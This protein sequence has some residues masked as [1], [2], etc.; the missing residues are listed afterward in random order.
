MTRFFLTC[1]R[2]VLH[3]GGGWRRLAGL[4]V[5]ALV[6]ML[7][8]AALP[9]QAT[10][11][12]GGELDLQYLRGE[13]YQLR[14]TL[15]FDMKGDLGAFDN[16]LTASLFE[17]GTNR[18]VRDVVLPIVSNRPADYTNPACARAE[19]VIRQFTYSQ[20][21]TLA[22]DKYENAAG[23]YVAVERCCRNVSIANIVAAEE[24]AQT[25]YLEFPA[26]GRGGSLFR[27][28]TPRL[29]PPLG[30]Y[31]CVGELFYADFSG[32]DADGD[33]LVY[34]L[35]TPLNGHATP[36]NTK[37]P[38]ASPAPYAPVRWEPR[39]AT[40]LP[41]GPDNQIPGRPALGIGR[42][43][44]RLTMRPSQQGLFVFGVRCQQFR[45]GEKIGETRRD[46]QLY[47]LSCPRN[48]A[49]SMTLRPTRPGA[50]AYR[51]GRDTLKLA[52][53]GGGRCLQ[54]RFTDPDP[55]SRLTARL[56]PVNFTAPAGELPAFT[57]TATGLVRATG[58]P[59]TLTATLCFPI[60]LDTKGK[61]YWLDV[62]VTDDGCSLPKID[63]LRV[64]FMAQ[65]VPNSAPTLSSTAGPASPLRA[66]VGELVRFE[67]TAT[68]PDGNPLTLTMSGNGFSPAALGA[69]LALLPGGPQLRG[70]FEWRVDCAAAGTAAV[71]R[72]FVFRASSRP[73][74]TEQ[75]AVLT[76]PI[77]IDYGNTAPRLA[78]TLPPA[79]AA[80]ALPPLVR[81]ALGESYTAT[82]TGTDAENDG[83]ILSATGQGFD[84]AAAGM[85][86]TA[87]G[88]AGQASGTFYWDAACAAVQLRREL[89][90]TFELRESTCQPQPQRRVVRFEVI[91]PDTVAFR[92]PNIITPNG[93]GKNDFFTFDKSYAEN[94]NRPVLP[95]N[96][97]DARFAGVQIFSRWGKSV[98]ES[99]DRQ[100]RWGGQDLA[101]TYYYLVTFTD[102]RRFKG[103][104]EVVL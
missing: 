14:L 21:I 35:V 11:I 90:V 85:R 50:L 2:A 19:L 65:P 18:W 53:T 7:V 99:R 12:V 41:L 57:T 25:F 75:S 71:A 49:P 88:G 15:Y 76:V 60:C 56:R 55:R 89:L 36:L 13:E 9:G 74:A 38:R 46:F 29:L 77:I 48:A 44:G 78:S 43:S 16:S 104:L 100:F 72:E 4:P 3:L 68:D 61:V 28:S 39:P 79:G 47:V 8:L 32:Q 73:C 64:A 84:L 52:T 70:R 91:S 98:Y 24:A 86:F 93:D 20:E 22:A 40:Q 33:S 81:R 10:H 26:I 42:Q 27:D 58:A 17:K 6:L 62:L 59:D 45:R 67:V 92:A 66:R 95:V 31:A 1:L 63:T 5:L 83:L 51:P 30:D 37:P 94:P 96:F 103:W 101:G 102:G 82:L 69:T 80:P 97:C 54:L 87:R 23:Y 34:D